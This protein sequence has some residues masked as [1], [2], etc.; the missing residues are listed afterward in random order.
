ML[1]GSNLHVNQ[2]IVALHGRKKTKALVAALLAEQ[3]PRGGTERRLLREEVYP[4]S[5][6]D[7]HSREPSSRLRECQDTSLTKLISRSRRFLRDSLQETGLAEV[8]EW[9]VYRHEERRWY[10]YEEKTRE[11]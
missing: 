5:G 11:A 8:F 4:L 3:D 9:F 1:K 6:A 7:G 2:H 10:L